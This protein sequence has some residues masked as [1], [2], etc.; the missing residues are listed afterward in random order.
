MMTK[1]LTLGALFTLLG[2]MT[3]CGGTDSTGTSGTSPGSDGPS[4]GENASAPEYAVSCHGDVL[5][6]SFGI[7]SAIAPRCAGGE[8]GTKCGDPCA[9]QDIVVRYV[10]PSFRCGG[11]TVFAWDGQACKGYPTGT[12]E[13]AMHCKGS[14]CE[15]LFKSEADCKAAFAQC[16]SP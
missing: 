4:S 1:T 2:A 6:A 12:E 13:G 16:S 9:A 14:D 3:A 7:A 15:E 10:P 11:T 8:A 5:K